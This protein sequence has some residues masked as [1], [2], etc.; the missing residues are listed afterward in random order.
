MVT[1]V[2][3][4]PLAAADEVNLITGKGQVSLGSFVNNSTT[5]IRLDGDLGSQG[6]TIDWGQQFGDSDVT[7]FRLDGVWRF[8]DRHHLRVLYT[9]YSRSRTTVLDEDIDWGDDTLLAGSNAKGLLEF[10]I[11]EAAY[12]YALRHSDRTELALTAG[13]HYTTFAATLTA[14]AD[15]G[16]GGGA[17]GTVGSKASVGAPLPVFGG[18]GLWRLGRSFY[19]NAQVQWFALSIDEYDGRILNYRA[20]VVWQPRKWIGIGVGY[21]YFNVNL[22]VDT[23]KFSG[24]LDWTYQGPQIFFNFGL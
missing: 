11:Y 6:T 22:D 3:L 18:S 13:L 9:D 15:T 12:E 19:L 23:S 10:S 21:D 4:A 1:L 2:L 17:S 20:D 7:R 24:S 14:D 16:G 8:N 5:K